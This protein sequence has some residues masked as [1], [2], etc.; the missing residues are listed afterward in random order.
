MVFFEKYKINVILV[1]LVFIYTYYKL[2]KFLII[3]MF[4]FWF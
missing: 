4:I 3:K 1:N 2:G